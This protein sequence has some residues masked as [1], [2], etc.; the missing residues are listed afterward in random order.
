MAI[1]LF[2]HSKSLIDGLPSYVGYF[3]QENKRSMCFQ[4]DLKVDLT[5]VSPFLSRLL[6]RTILCYME[7]CSFRCVCYTVFF[8]FQV[9]WQF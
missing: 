6:E 1:P 4:L 7:H 3:K 8:G 5:F 9:A 2:K